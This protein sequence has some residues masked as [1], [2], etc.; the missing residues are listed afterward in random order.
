MIKQEI[1]VAVIGGGPA[2]LATAI[3]AKEAGVDN[4]TIIERAD[5]LG[6]LL[7][8]CIHNGFGLFYFNEDMTGPQYAHRFIE[9]A[10][11]TGVDSM[12]KSM[13]LKI[14]PNRSVVVSNREGISYLNPK[15]IILTMGCRERTRESLRIP[16]TRPAGVFTAGTAQRYV[17]LDGYIPGKEVV[18]MGSGDIGMIM[19]RRLTLE[20]V[21]VK[22]VVE[23]LPYV[24]GLIRNEVQCL[25]DFDI[26]IY[27]KHTVTNIHGPERINAVSI[28]E[29]DDKWQP[30]EG[31]E[32]KIDCDTL[33]L[34]VGLIPENELSR[35]L[36]IELDPIT[37]GPVVNSRMETSVQGVFAGGN[38]VHVHDLVD[39]VTW[40]A[41]QAGAFAASFAQDG[42]PPATP[43]ITLRAGENI[44][45]TLPHKISREGGVT[46]YARVMEPQIK[47]RLELGDIYSKNKKIVKP[48]EMIKIELSEDDIKNIDEKNNKLVLDCKS[49]E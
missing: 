12:L 6:G 19:A 43:D 25:H 1:D 13:V 9:K 33:L 39:N 8:Q 46:I 18:I 45:Y 35:D 20:G 21:N 15:T 28:A 23:V 29:V 27:L 30:I 42:P 14:L 3:K 31:T 37:G 22:A 5:Y 2:G 49:R 26:P 24:G 47:V 40:E 38:V 16:G 10:M 36:G 41:E 34:S 32:Q 4:V 7:H 11:D 44:R 48:S 17:N